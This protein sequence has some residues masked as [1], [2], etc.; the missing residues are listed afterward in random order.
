MFN[1]HVVTTMLAQ[2]S[3]GGLSHTSLMVGSFENPGT[4]ALGQN[5]TECETSIRARE[6]AK[7]QV[8]ALSF[9]GHAESDLISRDV[10]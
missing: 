7:V 9:V 1:I 2:F 5:S 6:L 4:D 10:R 8:E 3:S